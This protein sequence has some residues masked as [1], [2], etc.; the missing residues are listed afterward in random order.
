M[1]GLRHYDNLG[2]A[3]FLTFS[4]F[5]KRPVFSSDAACSVFLRRLSELRSCSRVKILGY[6]VMPDHVHLVLYPPD[7]L[8]LGLAI[9][10]VKSL[11]AREI[12]AFGGPPLAVGRA[13]SAEIHKIWERRCYDHNCRTPET[14]REKIAYCHNN[15]VRR[16]LVSEPG[17]WEYSSFRW[18]AGE[19]EVP[20]GIDAVEL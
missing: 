5:R 3:R 14:V 10:Q 6:V 19:R 17:E 11:A 15:P 16:G 2:T 20:L 1:T 4:C 18:Y 7:G 8:R 13:S 12:L 9:G